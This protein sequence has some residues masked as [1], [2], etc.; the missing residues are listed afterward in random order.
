MLTDPR[1]SACLVLYH[2]G[3]RALRAV[4][5]LMDATLPVSIYVVDNSPRDV[6]ARAIRMDCPE[7]TILPQERN[8]GYGAGN[9]VVLPRL[10]SEYHLIMNPD[11]TFAPDLLERMVAYMDEHRDIAVLTPRVFSVDGQE[12][13]LPRRQPT[14]RYL[15]SG[16]L[17]GRS[18]RFAAWRREY[19]LADAPTDAP[20]KVQYATGCFLLIRSHLF[21][22]LGGFDER[23]FLYHEDS[24]LSRRVL[25]HGFIVYHPDFRVT[26]DWA[27]DSA[28]DPKAFRQHLLST[29]RFFNKW[30]WRW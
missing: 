10:R 15:M 22:K 29:I 19:T 26:H 24:D 2:S 25:D 17:E 23:F 16:R 18:K 11:V 30:G 6:I 12:Q 27:R 13:F 21:Y 7:A 8:I 4:R 20:M 3:S 5:C 28:S 14:V 1:I 9:N